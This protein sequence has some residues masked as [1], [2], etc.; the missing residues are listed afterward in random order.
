L[1][2]KVETTINGK[3]ARWSPEAGGYVAG[4]KVVSTTPQYGKETKSKPKSNT[5]KSKPVSYK[6]HL[7]S[8][9]G[10]DPS[11]YAAE[12]IKKQQAGIPLSDPE[13]AEEFKK[14]YPQYFTKAP[15]KYQ[16]QIDELKSLIKGQKT[17]QSNIQA[18]IDRLAQLKKKQALAQLD[19]A[20]SA[21]LSNLQQE[22]AG[23]AP[24]YYDLRNAA[25]VQNRLSAKSF[26]EYLA[27]RGLRDSGENT[28][29]RLM[30][31]AALQ[32]QIGALKRQE[33]QALEDIARRRTDIQNAYQSDLAATE[34]GLQAQALQALINQ[35]N[36]DRQYRLQQAQLA[37]RKELAQ[38]PYSQMTAAQRANLAL[39]EA[40]LTGLYQGQPTLSYR[41][42]QASPQAQDWYL[43]MVKQGMQR[44]I[45]APYYK[46][47]SAQ[48]QYINSLYKKM[49]SGQPL[50]DSEKQILGIETGQ[51]PLKENYEA[52]QTA[53]AQIYDYDTREEALKAFNENKQYMIDQGVNIEKVLRA[54]DNRW[55]QGQWP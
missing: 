17:Y 52:T 31:N 14:A 3:K 50:T 26:Q 22:Q 25:A 34:A 18:E 23:I 10:G 37:Q 7:S 2:F 11:K 13:A 54:I 8:Y 5:S 28:Q 20:R 35:M 39:Q 6:E 27:N 43:S 1:A 38:L 36:A 53:I 30:Q 40:G 29:A 4:G 49:A 12:I 55:P 32:G 42:W 45:N 48:E 44:D 21:A 24:K 19:K 9:F 47:P 15:D 46:P 41:Q 51:P 16:K 33:Q